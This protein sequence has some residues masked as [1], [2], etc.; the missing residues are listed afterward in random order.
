MASNQIL[1]FIYIVDGVRTPIGSTHK[2][3]KT[4]SA[5]QLAGFVIDEIC[6]RYPKIKKGIDQVVLGHAV[7][8][9]TGQNMARHAV[10]LSDLNINIPAFTINSVCGS[11]LQ[12]I[13]VGVQAILS[14]E[15]NLVLAGG[16]ESATHNPQIIKR[17][18]EPIESLLSDGL[19]CVMADSHMGELA[20]NLAKEFNISREA[21]DKLAFESHQ[22]AL[23]AQLQGKFDQEIVGIKKENGEIFSKD[24]RARKNISLEKMQRLPSSFKE[25][26]TVT[27]G[28][29]SSAADAAA[30]I[31]LADEQAMKKYELKPKAKI[32]GYSS[33]AIDPKDS[34]LG[35]IKAAEKCLEKCNLKRNDIDLF[36]I[37]ESF[38]S[39]AVLTKE[40]LNIEDAKFNIF[41]GDIALG[42]PLGSTATR[43]LTTLLYALEDQNKK[44]G[45]MSICFGGGGGVSMII[46]RL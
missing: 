9:G 38:A 18:Q 5:A 21:Q 3:L 33:V 16:A 40:R 2:S 7:S 27:P 46:E 19:W 10:F 24:E 4:F 13:I 30:I 12:S 8:A 23:Q 35:A 20:E 1:N 29:A 15:A 17:E 34:F 31:L 14:G 37:G 26:G 42:H 25:D 45:L 28:N 41:G 44:I 6:R 36:E 32:L 11:G 43:I 22:K 39:Q